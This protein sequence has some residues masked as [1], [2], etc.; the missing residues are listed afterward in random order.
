MSA[1]FCRLFLGID[2][3]GLVLGLAADEFKTTRCQPTGLG[4]I[5]VRKEKSMK[6]RQETTDPYLVV[7]YSWKALT[8]SEDF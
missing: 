6:M 4:A 1:S 2:E 7:L 5:K 8:P 3:A